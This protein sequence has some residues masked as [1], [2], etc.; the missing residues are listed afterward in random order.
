ELDG[1][2][3][4]R[5]LREARAAAAVPHPGVVT[6]HDIVS[7]DGRDLLVMELVEGR[8]VAAALAGGAPPVEVGVRWVLGV[9]DAL[10]AA[11][12]RGVLHRDIKAANVMV[13]DDG[14]VKVLD[15]GL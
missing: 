9:A 14:A 12:A 3:R 7:V 8:T 5:L 11:H 13:T 1:E 6:L 4:A 10:V 2:R 15:F